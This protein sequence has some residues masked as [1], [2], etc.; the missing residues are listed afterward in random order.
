M[1]L[2]ESL[3]PSAARDAQELDLR[4]MLGMAWLALKGWSAHEITSNLYPALT[5]AK[6]LRRHD[7]LLPIYYGLWSNLIWNGRLAES[8]SRSL[9]LLE[10]AESLGDS[11]LLLVAHQMMGVTHFWMGN[12]IVARKH[13]GYVA[14]VHVEEQHHHLV[15]LMGI[16]PTN[17]SAVYDSASTWILGYPYCAAMINEANLANARRRN[18]PLDLGYALS[19]G[20]LVLHFHRDF[21]AV[22]SRCE[23]AETLGQVHGL[24]VISGLLVPI[25]KGLALVQTENASDGISLLKQILQILQNLGN[26]I[27]MPYWRAVLAEGL[28]LTGDIAGG[29]REI[30]SS[31]MQ[32]ARPGREER[33][34]RAEILRLKGS[35]LE[36][37]GD[38]EAAEESY[39]SSL[40]WA[41][42]Q[43]AKSWEL[44]TATDL[45]RLWQSQAKAREAY[46]LLAPIYQ[47]FTEGFE[48]RDLQRARNLLD[49]LSIEI[50]H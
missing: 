21:P 47:W 20:Q 24:P 17:M 37:H 7:A 40:D 8:R 19:F 34:Y 36:R 33:A 13:A 1:Q 11:D 23:E 5:L 3:S 44:R 38:T 42:E 15:D 2:L 41:H 26:E 6:S 29:L 10:T 39:Q 50:S 9:E 4:T 49:Q 12:L 46:A 30:E 32:I 35:M 14:E 27:G 31:L 22:L 45:A 25:M 28:A 16:H 43:Q 48:T 18:H